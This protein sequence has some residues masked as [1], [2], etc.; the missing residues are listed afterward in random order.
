MKGKEVWKVVIRS[1]QYIHIEYIYHVF[2]HSATEAEKRGLKILDEGETR[3]EKLFCYS[4]NFDCHV[5]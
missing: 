3:E 4:V 2:A 5:Y 1:K